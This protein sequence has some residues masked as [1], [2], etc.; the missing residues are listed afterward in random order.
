ML[1][2]TARLL[3]ECAPLSEGDEN[4]LRSGFRHGALEVSGD[5]NRA[6][7]AIHLCVNKIQLIMANWT[8][9]MLRMDT[10]FM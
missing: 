1:T 8:G 5:V 6:E 7:R 10:F 4:L 2:R 3:D 9:C